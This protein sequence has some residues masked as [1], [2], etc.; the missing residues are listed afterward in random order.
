M[1]EQWGRRQ[2]VVLAV[3]RFLRA[4]RNEAGKTGA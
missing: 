3:R 4:V 2:S 1:P